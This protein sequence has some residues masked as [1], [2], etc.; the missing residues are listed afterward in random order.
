ML[1][2][3]IAA[4]IFFNYAKRRALLSEEVAVAAAPAASPSAEVASGP[5]AA[6]SSY[7]H[8][9]GYGGGYSGSGYSSCS[10][11]GSLTFVAA[12]SGTAGVCT[13]TLRLFYNPTLKGIM[14]ERLGLHCLHA[15]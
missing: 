2:D 10:R 4:Q 6:L 8:V 9:E 3:I 7:G 15:Y 12:V 14:V 11:S 1:M 5:A 13:S